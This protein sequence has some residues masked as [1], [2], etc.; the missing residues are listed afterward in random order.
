MIFIPILNQKIL[1]FFLIEKTDRIWVNNVKLLDFGQARRAGLC[2]NKGGTN[3]YKSPEQEEQNGSVYLSCKSDIYST[4]I[5]IQNDLLPVRAFNEVPKKLEYLLNQALQRKPEDRV[6]V[7]KML[8]EIRSISIFEIAF[9]NPLVSQLPIRKDS[10][11]S[12]YR[13]THITTELLDDPPTVPEEYKHQ[14]DSFKEKWQKEEEKDKVFNRQGFAL[15]KVTIS[16]TSNTKQEEHKLH[17]SFAIND[18]IH[19]RSMSDVLSNLTREKKICYFASRQHFDVKVSPFF[20]LFW[21]TY[22]NNH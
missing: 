7:Q 18:Y 10:C 2:K 9:K 16:R 13:P 15:K 3:G 11:P 20:K 14:Y 8:E 4:A 6:D 22:W 5:V 21:C 12:G 17:L 1:E 19:H